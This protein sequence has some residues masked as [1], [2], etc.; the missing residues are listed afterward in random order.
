MCRRAGGKTSPS[1]TF[2]SAKESG[3]ARHAFATDSRLARCAYDRLTRAGR[4]ALRLRPNRATA[5]YRL[6]NRWRHSP[7]RSAAA[8]PNRRKMFRLR[9]SADPVKPAHALRRAS[10]SGLRRERARISRSMIHRKGP[11]RACRL[12]LEEP[13]GGKCIHLREPVGPRLHVPRSLRIFHRLPRFHV[14]EPPSRPPG[15][16]AVERWSWKTL[17][18]M[19]FPRV[20]VSDYSGWQLMSINTPDRVQPRSDS[21]ILPISTRPGFV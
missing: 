5:N 13:P 11:R 4:T 3:P 21:A 2:R 12:R 16:S 14:H 15:P 18:I 8:V 17:V 7:H 19:T 20:A 1:R 9:R 6:K 10:E